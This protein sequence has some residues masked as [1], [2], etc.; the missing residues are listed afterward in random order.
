MKYLQVIIIIFVITGCETQIT[1]PL[2]VDYN[3]KDG[4]KIGF[5]SALPPKPVHRH[6][7]FT[8]FGNFERDLEVNWELDRYIFREL[9]SILLSEYCY[10]LVDL[11][12]TPNIYEYIEKSDT[13][14]R[15]DGLMTA[16]KDF[17][18]SF[19]AEFKDYELSGV[20]FIADFKIFHTREFERLDL[21]R[22]RQGSYGIESNTREKRNELS[23]IIASRSYSLMP[24]HYIGGHGLG[25][26]REEVGFEPDDYEKLSAEELA[27]Y[28]KHFK[29]KLS[30]NIEKLA[31]SLPKPK[32]V[33]CKK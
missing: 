4:A 11:S 25:I 32:G 1:N 23:S 24:I 16:N 28:E 13:P 6:I 17:I 2:P 3:Y 22:G 9:K 12:D 29:A 18:D 33:S 20:I 31:G 5:M 19:K 15:Q 7:G 26:Y 30:L 10:E 21:A 14:D 27:K 8:V